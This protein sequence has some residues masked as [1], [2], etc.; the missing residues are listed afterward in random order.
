MASTTDA[1][2]QRQRSW[3]QRID[4]E[5]PLSEL[6]NDPTMQLLMRRDGVA[7]EVLELTIKQAQA[8]LRKAERGVLRAA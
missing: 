5:P 1:I 2:A 8:V 7:P 4:G 3:R 6:L